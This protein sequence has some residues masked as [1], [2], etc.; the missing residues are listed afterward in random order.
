[1]SRPAIIIVVAVIF[2]LA[3]LSRAMTYTVRFTEQAVLTTF[4]KAGDGAIK[5]DAGLYFKWPD[6]IQSVTKYDT[7]ARF[8]SAKSETQQTAD[9][10]QLVVE[11]FCTWRVEDP[12]KFFQ[13]FSN[14]GDRAADHYSKAEKTIWDNLRSAMGEISRY[15]TDELFTTTAKASKLPELESKILAV[16]QSTSK[17]GESIADS[18]IRVLSVGINRIEL[19]EQTTQNVFESMRKERA[20]LV[21]EIESRA[22]AQAQTITS[23]AESSAKKVLA[24]ADAYAAEIRRRGDEEAQAY[25]AQTQEA[26]EFAV[27]LKEIEF[28]RT[29]LA[30][31]ITW[32]VDTTVPAFEL[33]APNALKTADPGTVPGVKGLMQGAPA[34]A[35]VRSPEPGG[36]R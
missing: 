9:N 31:R 18:G 28:I 8:L 27:F 23:E 26:P 19:P 30:K 1:V 7:R 4:G 22:A 15:R 35:T 14:A 24:F 2:A 16:L 21:G 5:K 29:S 32:I 33:L 12:L 3:L 36:G 25:I 10:K 20:T 17:E 34:A 6:P 13:R 11:S